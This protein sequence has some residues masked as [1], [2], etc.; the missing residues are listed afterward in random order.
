MTRKLSA[1]VPVAPAGHTIFQFKLRIGNPEAHFLLQFRPRTKVNES[2][3]TPPFWGQHTDMVTALRS[4]SRWFPY[5]GLVACLFAAQPTA[6]FA[7]RCNGY[8]QSVGGVAINADGVLSKVNVDQARELQQ[9][10]QEALVALP[11]AMNAMSDNRKISLRRMEAAIDTALKAGEGVPHEIQY[12]AGLQRIHYIFVYPDQQDIVLAGPAEGWRFNEQGAAVGLT[13]GRATMKLDDLLVA[14][15]SAEPAR[16]T[17]MSCSIDP[18][19]E[20]LGKLQSLARTMHS[21]SGNPAGAMNAIEQ[22]LGLQAITVTGVPSDSHFAQVMVAADYRMK[23]LA[24]H[25]DAAPVTGMPS[26]MELMRG[27]SGGAQNMLPRWWLEP[28][29]ETV[30][31]DADKMAWELRGAGVK[32]MTEDDYLTKTGDRQHTGKANPI[33]QRWADNM[34]KHYSDLAGRDSIFAQLINVMDMAIF[35]TL[36]VKEQL[37]E[38][39]GHDFALL[40]DAQSLPVEEFNPPRQVDSRASVLQKGKGWI[41]SAS[42]GVQ[43]VP[44]ALLEKIESSDKLPTTRER[45]SE[46]RKELWWWN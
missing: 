16:R 46:A 31:A 12:L 43:I 15:R 41:I 39:A 33:A 3:P 36:V 21:Y 5:V 6:A 10:M 20:G 40:M 38:K 8:R 11:G 2:A 24:M 7:Q 22:A 9:K 23:R 30:L 1:G 18:T 27:S 35:G 34:T 4:V 14:L 28:N 37:F 25:F 19:P 13:S 26:F 45:A 17:G 32:A 44:D 42:G 29:Y